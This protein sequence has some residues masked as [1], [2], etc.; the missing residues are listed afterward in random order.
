MKRFYL[1][2][3]CLLAAC[4]SADE[5]SMVLTGGTGGGAASQG[6]GGGSVSLGDAGA[7]DQKVAADTGAQFG[8]C[9][10]DTPTGVTIRLDPTLNPPGKCVRNNAGYNFSFAFKA[11]DAPIVFASL[12][13]GA[14]PTKIGAAV[15]EYQ[16]VA[17]DK[18]G[19]TCSG[20]GLLSDAVCAV[21]MQR[22]DSSPSISLYVCVADANGDVIGCSLFPACS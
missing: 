14:A 5:A 15:K 8:T 16:G 21:H 2:C 18:T 22:Q 1:V 7:T 17:I 20:K 19:D 13:V 12:A 6:G 9:S 11:C 10:R 3:V 4:G